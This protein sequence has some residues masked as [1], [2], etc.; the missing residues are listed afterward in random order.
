MLLI[1]AGLTMAGIASDVSRFVLNRETAFGLVRLFDLD[2]EGNIPTWYSSITL[3]GAAVLLLAITRLCPADQVRKWK[4]LSV[5]FLIA[6][7]DE[8]AQF[9]E[10][11]GMIVN[12]YVRFGGVLYFAWLVVAIP[13]VL[14][15][16]Y[17]FVPL[18][19]RLSR[20]VGNR[21]L[22]AGC[23]FLAGAVGMEMIS[24]V[25]ADTYGYANLG[26]KL[27]ANLEELLEMT[28]AAIWI[29]ALLTH[30]EVLGARPMLLVKDA[31]TAS[32][33]MR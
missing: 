18:L 2:G 15:L 25:Y 21:A 20:G 27:L 3:L 8:V 33:F 29:Y 19:F 14:V 28:G 26:F 17:T 6:S 4:M 10:S 13:I 9:H 11:T 31:K 30:L 16:A 1:V 32:I 12:R 24:G 7:I 23:V 5:V 22:F